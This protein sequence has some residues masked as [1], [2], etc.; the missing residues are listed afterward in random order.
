MAWRAQFQLEGG[1]DPVFQRIVRA[2]TEEIARGRLAPGQRLPGSRTLADSLG[3]HRN[4]VLAAYRELEAQGWVSTRPGSG[5]Y[6]ADAVDPLPPLTRLPEAPG[7]DLH[8]TAPPRLSPEFPRGTLV[9]AGGRP[10]LRLV[11]VA[12]IARAW[13]RGIRNSGRTLLDYGD[14]LGHPRLREALSGMLSAQRGVVPARRGLMVTRGSQMA[15]YLVARTLVRPGDRVAVEAF[16]YPPA[17]AAFRAAGAELVPIEVDDK[18]LRVDSLRSALEDGPIRALYLTPHHQFPTM[19]VLDASRRLELLTLAAERRFAVIEDDYDNEFH[20]RGRPVLPLAS[21]DR[22][23]VVV[24]VGTLSKVLAPG[25][26]MGYVA[27]PP[28]LI[29]QLAAHRILVDRQGDLATEYAVAE[30]IEEGS[31]ARHLRRARKAYASRQLALVDALR[32]HLPDVISFDVPPGGLAIWARSRRD[33]ATWQSDALKRGVAFETAQHH[34]FHGEDL[35]FI[36]LGFGGL[37]ETELHEAV[38]RLASIDI[39][40]DIR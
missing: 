16:G 7:F 25:L 33:V 36:R 14:Q 34:H 15:L 1:P 28:A 13:R 19:V 22:N 38:R 6:V 23:G 37:S 9:M 27:A 17:W 29:S 39:I 21:L 18:G 5:T 8:E 4:T 3:V 26:R 40:S 12:E 11:P 24:Y 31:L 10:D 32:T 2:L 30:L 35:Q 20:Y